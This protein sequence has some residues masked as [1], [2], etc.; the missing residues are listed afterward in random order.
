[1]NSR[2]PDQV[3]H[4]A[5]LR[6]PG[7]IVRLTAIGVV[8]AG[9]AGLFAYAGGWL[10]PRTLSPPLIVETFKKVS[11]RHSGF[12][13]TTRRVSA[14]GYF[15]SNGHG[16]RSPRLLFS[17]PVVCQSLDVCAGGRT[18]ICPMRRYRGSMAILFAA[19]GEEWRT[20]MI[21]YLFSR[22]HGS[23]VS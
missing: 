9:I 23:S 14:P 20:G 4:P 8:L 2:E 19:D 5:P 3:S 11:G 21:T 15:E 13:R 22:Q 18:A 17:F 1:M 6:G 7:L 16:L 10:T 12:R